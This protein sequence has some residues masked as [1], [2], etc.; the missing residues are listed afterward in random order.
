M[1][2][3]I[4]WNLDEIQYNVINLNTGTPIIL[5]NQQSSNYQC[6]TATI[7]SIWYLLRHTLEKCSIVINRET[8]AVLRTMIH[9]AQMEPGCWLGGTIQSVKRTTSY[10]KSVSVSSNL[11]LLF[12]NRN[13]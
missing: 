9:K 7:K 3:F 4:S 12:R 6:T 2:L 8:L 11:L 5:V 10:T 13:V 1:S